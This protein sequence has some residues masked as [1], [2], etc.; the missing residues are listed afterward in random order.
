MTTE[1]DRLNVLELTL[2][3]ECIKTERM[4]NQL[5]Q[6]LELLDPTRAT[7][8][9][10][11]PGEAPFIQVM[12]KDT[13]RIKGQAFLNSCNLYFLIAGRTFQSEQAHISWALT[14]FKS[15]QG[16]SFV[17][18]I[19][20]TQTST[21]APYF[22]NWKAFELELRKQFTLRNKQVTAITQLEGFSWYQGSDSVDKANLV[23][24]FKQG[25]NKS[26]WTMV[27]ATDLAPT[28][29]NLEVWIEAA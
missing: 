1:A 15:G 20:R 13:L 11:L 28:F 18:R 26:L 22:A 8:E 29:D 5:Q 17:D 16:A 6:L 14:F 24:K 25:L 4:E 2:A 19:L 12:D 10:A 21:H 9:L 7:A 23:V 3:E 27:A